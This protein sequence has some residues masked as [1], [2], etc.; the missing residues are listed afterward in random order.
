MDRLTLRFRVIALALGAIVGLAIVGIAQYVSDAAVTR[1]SDEYAAIDESYER[2]SAFHREMLRLRVAE[3]RLRAE[4]NA[5]ILPVLEEAR[6]DTLERSRAAFAGDAPALAGIEAGFA[7]YLGA[8]ATYADHLQQ[9]GYRDRQTIQVSEEGKAGI[10]SPTGYTV[11]LSNA[12]VKVATRIAEE[13][14]FD[15]QPAVFRVA[16]AFERIRQDILR[17]VMEADRDYVTQLEAKFDEVTS[18]LEEGD[19]DSTFAEDVTALLDALRAPLTNLSQTEL[20]LAEA[21]ATVNGHYEEIDATLTDVVTAMTAKADAIR[22]TLNET[23]AFWANLIMI[24]AALTLLVLILA[25]VLIVR[26]VSASLSTITRVTNDLARG[27][28]DTDIPYTEERTE[29]GELARALVVFRDNA[30]ERA[31]LEETATAENAAKARRQ[32]AVDEIIAE[33]KR[34]IVEL[35]AAGNRAIDGARVSADALREAARRNDEQA[36]SADDASERASTNVQTVASATEELNA[37]I[38]EISSQVSRT[39]DLITR[40]ADDARN[41]NADVD[42]LA[43]AASK[44]GEIITLI[45][46]IAEQTNLLALNA[47]IEAAR[48]GEH[49]RGFSIVASEVKSLA[50]QTAAATDEIAGQIKAIQS[51]SRATVSAI[52]GIAQIISSVQ[53][54]AAS[55]AAAIE[56]QNAATGE[57]SRNIAGAADGTRMVAENVSDLRASTSEAMHSA[58]RIRETSGEVGAIN[59]RIRKRID[60]FLEKVAVA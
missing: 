51:S 40:A 41:T 26:S 24:A 54:N 30:L 33:F 38:G 20:S 1:A 14:E 10:D 43:E 44:I 8:L 6:G 16:A 9:L 22:E 31:R 52:S 17:L 47:T 23:R 49:G 28:T 32:Q 27:Q 4:R 13:L 45:Q 42:Q 57:I 59:E 19:L 12:A 48:A 60:G 3:Q 58:N 11:D 21:E 56:E 7:D 25:G 53:D 18:L 15:D 36:G 34:D 39:A 2:L 50:N 37:S 29:L 46:A 55:I 5:A 35:L